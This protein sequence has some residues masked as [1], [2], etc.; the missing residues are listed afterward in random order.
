ME[1]T[2]KTLSREGIPRA[3]EKAIRYR[4]LNEP[5]QAESICR[6]I[7]AVDPENQEALVTLVLALT[8]QFEQYAAGAPLEARELL[9]RIREEYR[10][11]YY[12]GVISERQGKAILKQNAPSSCFVAYDW[13]RQ[14]MDCYEQAEAVRPEG[15]EDSILRWNTCARIIMDNKLEQAEDDDGPQLLE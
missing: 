13:F 10:Q 15:N 3:V 12:A 6:D 11:L 7:L 4:L 1:F 14:A 9:P 8:G 5:K 2:L